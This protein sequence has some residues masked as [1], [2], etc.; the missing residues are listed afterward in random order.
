MKCIVVT[1]GSL[2]TDVERVSS[3]ESGLNKLLCLDRYRGDKVGFCPVKGLG[4]NKGALAESIMHD[5]HHVM[6]AGAQ[7]SDLLLAVSAVVKAGGGMAV[8][9]DGS[10]TLLPLPVGGL[11]TTERYE[12]LC[13]Q[14]RNL[15]CAL[16]KTGANPH[17]FMS[18]SF[19]GLTVIPH[20]KLT[21]RGLFDGDTF[22][23]VPLEW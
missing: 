9:I 5:A 8:A 14:L 4:I 7:D 1:D 18:V 13:N 15:G 19:L 17:A 2:L 3:T 16:K 23:D 6:A 11:M 20:L 22:T 21:P 12:I 10:V